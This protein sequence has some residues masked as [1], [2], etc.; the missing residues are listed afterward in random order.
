MTK[1]VLAIFLGA[2]LSVTTALA[3]PI[4]DYV[5][6]KDFISCMGGENPEQDPQRREY[7]LCVRDSMKSWT[8]EEYGQTAEEETKAHTAAQEPGRLQD[9]AKACIAKVLH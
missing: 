6:D 3:E 5:L 1:T 2:L 8:L 4:P 9:I 7:C